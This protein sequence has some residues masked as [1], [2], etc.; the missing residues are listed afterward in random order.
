TTVTHL[1]S[2]PPAPSMVPSQQ[3]PGF[4][5][6]P[7]PLSIENHKTDPRPSKVAERF[8]FVPTNPHDSIFPA[9]DEELPESAS[10]TNDLVSS[11]QPSKKSLGPPPAR[12]H[13]FACLLGSSLIL[14]CPG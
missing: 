5:R 14:I 6:H 1:S 2:K 13:T 11:S 8:T 10:H 12:A 3:P 7:L 9:D 4:Y